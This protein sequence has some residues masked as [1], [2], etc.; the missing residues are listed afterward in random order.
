L[1]DINATRL[2][3]GTGSAAPP[4]RASRIGLESSVWLLLAALFLLAVEW[5]AYTRRL[6]A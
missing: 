3:H 4:S 5:F 2:A 1:S 6:T